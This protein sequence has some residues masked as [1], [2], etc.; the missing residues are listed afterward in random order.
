[1][2]LPATYVRACVYVYTRTRAVACV[3]VYTRTRAVACVYV[4]TRTRAVAW[5]K[6][7]TQ[8]TESSSTLLQTTPSPAGV[9]PAAGT[10]GRTR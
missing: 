8:E 6:R 2:S 9:R 4:Y 7:H 5:R 10:W 3:Y 1:M